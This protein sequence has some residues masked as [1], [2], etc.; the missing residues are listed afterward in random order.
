MA[1]ATAGAV[2]TVAGPKRRS[3]VALNRGTTLG[4]IRSERLSTK[5]HTCSEWKLTASDWPSLA[6]LSQVTSLV[7]RFA[8]QVAALRRLRVALP[9][10]ARSLLFGI[11]R[12]TTEVRDMV[13][14]ASVFEDAPVDPV[15]L[16]ERGEGMLG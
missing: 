5:D 9:A 10:C 16:A 6:P 12:R 1:A 11:L 2:A 15:V 8:R 14:Q 4:M 13:L 3:T 7:E